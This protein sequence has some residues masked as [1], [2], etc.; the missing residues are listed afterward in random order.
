LGRSGKPATIEASPATPLVNQPVR[1]TLR[2]LDQALIERRAGEVEVGVTKSGATGA[3]GGTGASTRIVLR[4]ESASIENASVATYTG[5]WVPGEAGAFAI[6]PADALLA[7]LE[8]SASVNVVLPEDELRRP[9]TD[10][11][12]LAE[13]AQ[14]TGGRVLMVDELADLP[15]ILPNREVRLL[16]TPEVETLWD[17]PVALLL[18]LVLLSGEWIGRRLLRLA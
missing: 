10:H 5:L 2:L 3:G 7:G 11:A 9:Q 16:G 15:K 6:A 14:A 17:K 13:L 1:V 12:A 8:L 4:P 18:L